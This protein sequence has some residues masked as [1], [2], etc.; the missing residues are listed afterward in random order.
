MPVPT[1]SDVHVPST[2][3]GKKKSGKA[4]G[5]MGAKT[6]K[7]GGKMGGKMAPPFQPK[8]KGKK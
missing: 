4:A 2:G 6:G 1:E 8:G 3:G 7:M 5:A